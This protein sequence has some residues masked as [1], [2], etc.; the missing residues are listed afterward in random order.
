M[1]VVIMLILKKSVDSDEYDY[2][3]ES[4]ESGEYDKSGYFCEFGDLGDSHETYNA[5]KS[6]H[7]GDS[8]FLVLMNLVIKINLVILVN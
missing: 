3:G 8:E 7:C 4:A 1:I 5:G 6:N 2:S